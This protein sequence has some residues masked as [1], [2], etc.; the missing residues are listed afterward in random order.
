[1][2]WSVRLKGLGPV[3]EKLIEASPGREWNVA[4]AYGALIGHRVIGVEKA[5]VADESILATEVPTAT[6]VNAAKVAPPR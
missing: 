4:E 1:M 2:L 6:V 3:M 5:V